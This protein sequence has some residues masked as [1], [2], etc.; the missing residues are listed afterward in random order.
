[1]L[2]AE[3]GPVGSSRIERLILGA[4]VKETTKLRVGDSVFQNAGGGRRCSPGLWESV[5]L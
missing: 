4:D 1:M 2:T 5:G 3:R